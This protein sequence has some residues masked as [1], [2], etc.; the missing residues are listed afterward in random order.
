MPESYLIEPPYLIGQLLGRKEAAL[1]STAR[2]RALP[3]GGCGVDS[4]LASPLS[5]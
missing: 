1:G 2:Q 3:K 4:G 5:I